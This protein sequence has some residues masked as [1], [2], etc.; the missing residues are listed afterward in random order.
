MDKKE[1]LNEERYQ[2]TKGKIKYIILVIFIIGL[3]LGGF[4]I[5]KGV[6]STN[7]SSKAELKA[8]LEEKKDELE[9]KGIV[10]NPFATYTDK[11]EYDL[12]I[13]TEALDPSFDNCSFD[14]YKNNDLTKEYCSANSATSNFSKMSYLM[15]G[16]FV[17]IA[18]CILCGG[19]YLNLV[20]RREILAYTAQQVMPVAQEGIE[21]MAPSIGKVAGEIAKNIKDSDNKDK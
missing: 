1:Y 3:A 21:K 9:E 2:K 4:L 17:I 15:F 20:K 5:Y 6:S 10:Y 14:E 19:L 11:E 7:S 12:K 18:S 16:G 8:E 13:I